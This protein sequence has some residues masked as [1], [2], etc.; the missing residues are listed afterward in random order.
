MNLLVCEYA[1]SIL[2]LITSIDRLGTQQ[3]LLHQVHLLAA[4]RVDYMRRCMLL[5]M[6]KKGNLSLL[7]GVIVAACW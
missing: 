3:R 2:L 1:M 5:G 6:E 4:R 7:L